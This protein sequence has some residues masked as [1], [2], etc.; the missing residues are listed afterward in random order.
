MKIIDKVMPTKNFSELTVGEVFRGYSSVFIRI[1]HCFSDTQI[2]NFLDYEGS[3]YSVDELIDNES[4]YNAVNLSTG[5][6][7]HFDD[8][9]KVTPLDTEL[10]I[11]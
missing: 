6:L 2:E 7:T 4:G 11:L 8:F 10:H 5:A 3:M 9:Y 1:S